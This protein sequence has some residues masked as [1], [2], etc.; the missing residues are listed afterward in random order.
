[1]F[2]S[3]L[4]IFYKNPCVLHILAIASSSSLLLAHNRWVLGASSHTLLFHLSSPNISDLTP[5]V[6][7]R[8]APLW[9]SRALYD[10][11]PSLSTSGHPSSS[12]ILRLKALV[13]GTCVNPRNAVF[14]SFCTKSARSSRTKRASHVRVA[15]YSQRKMS[16]KKEGGKMLLQ[17]EKKSNREVFFQLYFKTGCWSCSAQI[18]LFHWLDSQ[19]CCQNQGLEMFL[20]FM[21]RAKQAFGN[22]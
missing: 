11:W 6:A 16:N 3:P 5:H 7:L 18:F 15:V 22:T 9:T 4:N 1:M 12:R 13:Q 10:T 17:L 21:K 2:N 20:Q 14:P 8:T 19:P